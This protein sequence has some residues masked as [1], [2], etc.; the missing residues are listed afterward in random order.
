MTFTERTTDARSFRHWPGNVEAD[1]IY[2]SGI[3]GERFFREL[4]DHGRLMGTRCSECGTQWVP[5][6]LFCE[7]CFKEVHDWVE[8]PRE[9]RVGAACIVGVALDGSRLSAPEAWGASFTACSS[10]RIARGRASACGPSSNQKGLA[11]GPSRTSGASRPDDTEPPFP[12][13]P[14]MRMVS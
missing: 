14:R 13:A 11:R 2:T 3:A 5:P 6:K 7:E 10:R 9:G 12:P 4:R 1:Y 8:L